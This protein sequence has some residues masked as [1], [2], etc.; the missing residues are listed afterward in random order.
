MVVKTCP[1]C[2]GTGVVE[3]GPISTH[4]GGNCRIAQVDVRHILEQSRQG[5]SYREIGR[6]NGIRGETAKAIVDGSWAGYKLTGRKP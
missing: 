4:K 2:R 3:M 6:L 1:T 5:K